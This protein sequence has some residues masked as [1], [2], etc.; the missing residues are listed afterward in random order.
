MKTIMGG[1]CDKRN[2]KTILGINPQRTR[3]PHF[4]TLRIMT[5]PSQY[6]LYLR[7]YWLIIWHIFLFIVEYIIN[8]Q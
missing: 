3:K 1:T 5:L 4:K 6:I 2:V 7:N 8:L